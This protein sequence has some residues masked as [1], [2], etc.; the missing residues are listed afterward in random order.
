MKE[1]AAARFFALG[2]DGDFSGRTRSFIHQ[3]ISGINCY[4]SGAKPFYSACHPP[5]SR[6]T[7]PPIFLPADG[8]V[9]LLAADPGSRRIYTDGSVIGG[10][11]GYGVV[12]CDH[13]QVLATCR[14]RLP[15]GCSIFQ[16][17]GAAIRA[18]LVYLATDDTV[19]GAVDILVDSRA[20]LDGCSAAAKITTLYQEI[21]QLLLAG[22]ASVRLFWVAAHK[23][24]MGNELADGLAKAGA[25]NL[26]EVTDHLPLP[27]ST[28]KA[29]AGSHLRLC[30]EKEWQSCAK[31]RTTK[32][33]L[34]TTRL[35]AALQALSL[36]RE[37]TQ[38]LT[39]HS[40][41]GAHLHRLKLVAAPSCQCGA[42]S[43]T[44]EHV[45][46]DC[47]DLATHRAALR[48]ALCRAGITWPP[49]L[50]QLCSSPLAIAGLAK[51]AI[52]SGRFSQP[53]EPR[54]SLRVS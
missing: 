32:Q 51:F 4:E 2:P 40:Y 11:T 21:R 14:V 29:A 17:E 54:R 43:E 1:I 12:V 47:A 7:P 3:A 31:G 33:F 34:P 5:W 39:G 30:W 52:D 24:H 19:S 23:G 38:I 46:L 45:I 48:T 49:R 44:I 22:P 37:L 6:R 27:L 25:L 53:A 10:R 42:E 20:A 26:P 50:S 16:A 18:A 36:T 35:P 13:E 8:P 9:P 28:A 15:D 41:L